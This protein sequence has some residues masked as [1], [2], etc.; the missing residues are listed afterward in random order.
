MLTKKEAAAHLN[1][2]ENTVTRWA[3][4]G[5]ITAHSYNGH[6]CL[7]EIPD[8]DMPQKQSSRWNRLVE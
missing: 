8:K 5:L 1:I 3:K 6:Y 2:H 4:Y 7:Y